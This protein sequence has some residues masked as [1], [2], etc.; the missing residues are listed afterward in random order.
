MLEG[1]GNAHN[2]SFP[3]SVRVKPG[4]FVIATNVATTD[5]T[6]RALSVFCLG[7]IGQKLLLE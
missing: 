7:I 5:I 1:A 3:S 6:P 2:G 4:G